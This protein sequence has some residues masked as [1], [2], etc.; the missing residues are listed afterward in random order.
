MILSSSTV[1]REREKKR[2]VQG[3]E[4]KGGNFDLEMRERER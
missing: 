1:T 3:W 4:K 2:Y